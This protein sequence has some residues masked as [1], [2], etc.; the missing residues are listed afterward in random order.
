MP[1]GEELIAQF[2]LKYVT[3]YDGTGHHLGPS[4]CI[5]T[6]QRLTITDASGYPHEISLRDIARV[7][8]PQSPL[9]WKSVNIVLRGF[10]AT[11]QMDCR[12]NNQTKAVTFALELA[13]RQSFSS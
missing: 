6:N 11:Y 3:Y 5:L 12:D 10:P 2:E 7:G 1:G 4:S 9:L 13:I 8:P